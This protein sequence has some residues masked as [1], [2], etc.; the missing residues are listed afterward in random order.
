MKVTVSFHNL[1]HTPSLDDRIQEK[2]AK[3]G[4]FLD[5]KTHVKWHCYVKE[6]NHYAEVELVGPKFDYHAHGHSDCLYKTI[7]IVMS[8]IEKQLV[9]K[10]EKFKNKMHRSGAEP[11]ILEPNDAWM[12]YDEDKFDDVS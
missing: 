11:E 2:S 7:D 5:G 1:E 8:K 6:H 10:K 12:D 3:L 9:K 4:K